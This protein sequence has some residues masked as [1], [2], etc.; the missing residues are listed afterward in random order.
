MLIVIAGVGTEM[1]TLRIPVLLG[2]RFPLQTI[3]YSSKSVTTTDKDQSI[4][5]SKMCCYEMAAV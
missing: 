4:G 3:A 2:T 1:C 5:P